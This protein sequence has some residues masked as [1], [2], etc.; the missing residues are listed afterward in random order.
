MPA[1][2]PLLPRCSPPAG[3]GPTPADRPRRR[4]ASRTFVARRRRLGDPLRI[5]PITR[6]VFWES[7]A[8]P[9]IRVQAQQVAERISRL[10]QD[11]EQGAA[12]LALGEADRTA[13]GEHDLAGEA[14]ADSGPFR[15]GRVEGE[16]ESCSTLRARRGHCPRPRSGCGRRE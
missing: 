6:G 7:V 3:S 12:A 9:D 2:R 14:E 8:V 15:L 5:G 11:P 13:M 10:D 16:E 4:S 1:P